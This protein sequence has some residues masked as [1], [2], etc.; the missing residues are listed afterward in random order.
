MNKTTGLGRSLS[1]SFFNELFTR[2]F[3]VSDFRGQNSISINAN[4]EYFLTR[5]M[6]K[7]D[8][9]LENKYILVGTFTYADDA[10]L[11]NARI[12]DNHSGHIIAAARSYYKTK[13]CKILGNCQEPRRLKIV[14]NDYKNSIASAKQTQYKGHNNSFNI[15]FKTTKNSNKIRGD[16]NNNNERISLIY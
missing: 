3:D 2:G 10:I 14:G 5:D 15:P 1:E 16:R 12:M 9:K 4:G 13:D 6:N 7:L 11:I 8:K